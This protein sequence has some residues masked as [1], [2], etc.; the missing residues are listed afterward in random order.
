MDVE[1]DYFLVKFKNSE[2][3]ERVLCHDPWVYN[4]K[5]WILIQLSRIQARLWHGSDFPG[6]LDICI[7]GK[8]C[9]K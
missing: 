7:S 9:K 3:Y 5:P 6:Y 4:H 1:N 2:D 8:S